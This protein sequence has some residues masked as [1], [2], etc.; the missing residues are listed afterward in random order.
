MLPQNRNEIGIEHQDS[1]SR[2]RLGGLEHEYLRA[3]WALHPPELAA[4]AQHAAVKVYILPRQ[5][6]EFALAVRMT[7]PFWHS[8]LR[9]RC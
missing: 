9:F 8:Y 4:D 1:L 3:V 2:L 6:K 5:A 7:F